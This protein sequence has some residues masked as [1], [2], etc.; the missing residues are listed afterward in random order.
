VKIPYELGR[1]ITPYGNS[2]ANN[3]QHDFVFDVTDYAPLLKDSSDIRAFYSGWSSGFSAT[4]RFAFIEG[5][6]ARKVLKVENVYRGSWNYTDP[7][8]FETQR[9]PAKTLSID[10]TTKDVMLR[11]N[12]TGH[13]FV[14]SLGCA[15]FCEKDYIVKAGGQ[16]VA[17]QSMW[18]DD[19]GLNP[20]FPQ[21]GTWLYD[22]ANWCPGDKSWAYDHILTSYVNNGSLDLDLDI[23][24]YNYTVPPNEV[25]A[26]YI[27]EA[28]LFQFEAP[29]LEH[30]IELL[31]ILIPS[32]EDEDARMNPVCGKA[33]VK[34]NNKGSKPVTSC[35]I[36]YGVEGG[37]PKTFQWTGNLAFMESEIVELPFQDPSDWISSTSSSS[38]YAK[39]DKPNGEDDFNQ[40]NNWYNTTFEAPPT[41]PSGVRF[42]IKTNNA[43]HETSW[44]VQSIDGTVIDSDNNLTNNTTYV[45]NMSLQPGCYFLLVED[46]DKD[47]LNFFAN[48]DGNGSI[49][50]R[51]DGG[52]F[53]FE[54]LQNNFG[55]EMRH[56]FTVGYSIGQKEDLINSAISI[57]PNPAQENV[58]FDFNTNGASNALLKLYDLTGKVLIDKDYSFVDSHTASI[59]VSYLPAGVYQALVQIGEDSHLEKIV[60][61]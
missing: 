18:R 58:T 2:L 47:G 16:T 52:T 11:V 8:Q 40:E 3:W 26:N 24:A 21:D 57:Y 10:S 4:V 34:I 29:T 49:S 35:T 31:D 32:S 38:F 56:Y 20:I 42:T 19:C 43:A 33:V 13:G 60:I 17:T 39:A 37:N 14:N 53:F 1:V 45:K 12:I 55:T 50:L 54:T 44:S 41:Y 61:Q 6:P 46:S 5:T 36:E 25:P 22:R 7:N 28:Q 23:E 15:E 30:D 9:L 51:N 48:N 27:I 59:D